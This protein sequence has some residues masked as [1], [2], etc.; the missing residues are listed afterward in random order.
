MPATLRE[1][2]EHKRLE[3]ERAKS[4]TPIESLAARVKDAPPTRGFF[5]ALTREVG[6]H[7]TR[8]IAEVKRRSPSAGLIRPEYDSDGFAPERIAQGYSK[9][10]ASAISCLTDEKFFGGRLSFMQRIKDATD[11][12]VLRKD[13]IIDPYQLYE[14]RANAA[15]AVL[16]IAEC[17]SDPQI[18]QLL[19][20][21]HEL[22][23]GV[24]LEVHSRDNLLRA[25]P[26]LTQS[27]HKQALLG[28]NNRD[29]TRMITDLAHTTDL[30]GLVDHPGALVSESGIKT[31][32][33]LAALRAHGIRT[34]LIGEHLMRQPDPG[35]AL[36]ELLATP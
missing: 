30:L 17:L 27:P 2:V 22:D 31:P 35:A 26:L 16:L 14:A 23:L 20:L 4:Q 5:A 24:L 7:E 15:D 13:F 6:E 9:A 10:G 3:I 34:A 29:L 19:E 28:V 8:V 12:P 25:Q 1:I 21:A 33:D 11:L 18:R 36:A 32:Q